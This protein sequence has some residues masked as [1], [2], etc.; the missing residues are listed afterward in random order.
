MRLGLFSE[1]FLV[2][3][4]RYDWF[5][6]GDWKPNVPDAWVAA[7]VAARKAA[8]GSRRSTHGAS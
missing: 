3:S 5:G 6:R 4:E 8:A 2:Y 1:R 7:T